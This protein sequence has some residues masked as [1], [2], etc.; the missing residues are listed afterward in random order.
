MTVS[1]RV[2][3]KQFSVA[4]GK[5]VKT[6]T[7]SESEV[8]ERLQQVVR[9]I[10]YKHYK[11]GTNLE[12][13]SAANPEEARYLE[14]YTLVLSLDGAKAYACESNPNPKQFF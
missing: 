4:T 13:T 5:L 1:Q 8:K 12:I 3:I 11:T 2:N 6:E 7:F 14:F 10:Q 9:Q